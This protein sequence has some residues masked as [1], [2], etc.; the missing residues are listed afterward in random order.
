MAIITTTAADKAM[1]LKSDPT[2]SD[3]EVEMFLLIKII[4][5]CFKILLKSMSTTTPYLKMGRYDRLDVHQV[6]L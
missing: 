6:L 3:L 4:I 2:C 5:Y 1:L